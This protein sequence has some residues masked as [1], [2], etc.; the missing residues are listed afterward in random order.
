MKRGLGQ[1]LGLV[2]EEHGLVRS[3]PAIRCP[4]QFQRMPQQ[5]ET[6][7][8]DRMHVAVLRQLM[9]DAVEQRGGRQHFRVARPPAKACFL[10]AAE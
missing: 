5:A 10:N 9:T 7:D 3:G 2:Q 6:G 4:R 1:C 8:V